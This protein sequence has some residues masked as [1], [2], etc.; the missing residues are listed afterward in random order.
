[1]FGLNSDYDQCIHSSSKWTG[2]D[3]YESNKDHPSISLQG[4]MIKSFLMYGLVTWLNDL[5]AS[6]AEL[7]L[8]SPL[9]GLG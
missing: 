6:E 1:M 4:S 8:I 2:N 9:F 7:E 5:S 3:A